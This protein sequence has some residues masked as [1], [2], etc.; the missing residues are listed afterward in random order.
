[1]DRDRRILLKIEIIFFFTESVIAF[2]VQQRGAL[3]KL[4]QNVQ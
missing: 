3:M 4:I 2:I 1:M